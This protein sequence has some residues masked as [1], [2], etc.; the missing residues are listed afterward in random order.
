MEDNHLRTFQQMRKTLRQQEKEE[1]TFDPEGEATFYLQAMADDRGFEG[2]KTPTV[3][4]T[5]RESTQELLDI[6]IGAEKNSI[7][8]YVGLKGLVPEGAGRD[9]VE[10]IIRE[11][12]SHLAELR[13]YLAR[14]ESVKERR[15]KYRCLLCS[16][17]YDPA[18]GDPD[19]GVGPGTAFQDLPDNWVC[20][21]CGAGKE[22][23]EPVEEE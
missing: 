17:V 15:M 12:A 14:L 20:P 16:Y 23:F 11:E 4:L 3:K 8:Y 7:L 5:G 21:E 1:T 9:K 18:V 19:N 22:E 10:V 13:R 6:A 2:K